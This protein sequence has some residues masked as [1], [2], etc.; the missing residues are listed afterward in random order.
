MSTNQKSNRATKS[1]FAHEANEKV[2]AKYDVEQAQE[3]LRWISDLTGEQFDISGQKDNFYQQ[4]KDGRKLCQLMNVLNPN[5][6]SKINPGENSF[7]LMENISKFTTAA[8]NYGLSDSET[9]QTVDLFEQMNLHQVCLCLHALE[10]KAQKK[11]LSGLGPREA[12]KNERNFSAET[13][14]Q[15]N[16]IIGGQ[17]GFNK[18]R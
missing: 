1:G 6:I 11:G 12:E 10:R 17:L 13:L 14:N 9:F 2:Q 18:A 7:K 5:S 4:L 3:A 16:S 15:G 8:K